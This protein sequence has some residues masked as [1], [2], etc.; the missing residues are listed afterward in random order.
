[1]LLINIVQYILTKYLGQMVSIP[2][3]CWRCPG[4]NVCKGTPAVQTKGFLFPQSL[5]AN[6]EVGIYS[7]VTLL[8]PL[9]NLQFIFHLSSITIILMKKAVSTSKTSVNFGDT[10]WRSIAEGCRLCPFS[11]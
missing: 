8:P 1:M 9:Y 5:E 4:L 6:D 3:S 10:T 7:Y 11:Q 2:V